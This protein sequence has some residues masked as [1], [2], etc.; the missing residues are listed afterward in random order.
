MN[1]V[2]ELLWMLSTNWNNNAA[3]T[4]A[5]YKILSKT[6]LEQTQIN[7]NN[8]GI[9][10][11]SCKCKKDPGVWDLS[12]F[13][14]ILLTCGHKL[15]KWNACIREFIFAQHFVFLILSGQFSLSLLRNWLITLRLYIQTEEMQSPIS[16]ELN[17]YSLE[18]QKHKQGQ[19]DLY[20]LCWKYCIIQWSLDTCLSYLWKFA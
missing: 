17:K 13:C 19:R 20:H 14:K 15:I 10:A 16:P 4:S 7:V 18:G 9:V 2:C 3:F 8:S 12:L 11:F 5:V 1:A 6:G